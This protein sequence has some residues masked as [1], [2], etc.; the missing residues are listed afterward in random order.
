MMEQRFDDAAFIG[1]LT[2]GATH[3]IRNVL[4]VIKESA[5]LM[6][7]LLEMGGAGEFT[8]HEKFLRLISNI[9][10]Q[11]DRGSVV[12]KELNTLAHAPDE[13]LRSVDVGQVLRSQ[14]VL[15][16]RFCRGR[17]VKLTVDASASRAFVTTDPLVLHSAVC[18]VIDAIVAEAPPQTELSVTCES[19]AGGV[20]IVFVAREEDGTLKLVSG[21]S[22]SGAA[23][24]AAREAVELV[25][26]RLDLGVSGS[27]ARATLVQNE[28]Q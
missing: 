27:T 8:H 1:K 12:A 25:G 4:S 22:D 13:R 24:A 26:G 5:G 15:Y 3:E 9:L 23:L 18:A 11:V 19:A 21:E 6:Q 10:T 16:A 20:D 7:D 14:S 17:Q 2:A 28:T